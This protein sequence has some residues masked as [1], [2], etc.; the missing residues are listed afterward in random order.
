MWPVYLASFTKHNVFKIHPC[1]N[2]YWYFI[3][4]YLQIIVHC[5]DNKIH[6]SIHQL[7]N[8]YLGCFHFLTVMN[9]AALNT[10]VQIFVWHVFNSTYLEVELLGHMETL[11]LTFLGTASLYSKVAASFHNLTNNFESSNF[12]AFINTHFL[13]FKF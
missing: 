12:S 13:S 8:G 10:F 2:M 4:V 3:S 6:L 11:C 5:I 1:C 7:V 9:D